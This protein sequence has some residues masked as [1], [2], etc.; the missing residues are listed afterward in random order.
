MYQA[1]FMF[2]TPP[3]LLSSTILGLCHVLN[4]ELQFC[5]RCLASKP[6]G[7]LSL[8]PDEDQPLSRLPCVRA[9]GAKP[10]PALT[11]CPLGPVRL[12]GA[13][14]TTSGLSASVL[15][16]CMNTSPTK[17]YSTDIM[18][19]TSTWNPHDSTLNH[20]IHFLKI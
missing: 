16:R 2:L 6:C 15:L 3:D 12:V 9:A 8:S 19:A 11:P 10:A 1:Q 18:P 7:Y 14:P 4:V 13:T 20:K 5:H 17:H